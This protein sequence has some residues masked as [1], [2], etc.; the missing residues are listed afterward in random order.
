MWP[1]TIH[2]DCHGSQ[3][4]VSDGSVVKGPAT[5]PLKESNVKQFE[6]KVYVTG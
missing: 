5:E 2:C 1:T 4:S 3:F 6:K